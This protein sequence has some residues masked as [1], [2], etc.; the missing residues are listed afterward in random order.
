MRPSPSGT[1]TSAC[2]ATA[3]RT[4][5][6]PGANPHHRAAAR[7]STTDATPTTTDHARIAD[8]D[9]ATSWA[10]ATGT[11]IRAATSRIP[12]TRIDATMVT[13]TRTASSAFRTP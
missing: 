12:T 8:C 7:P 10:L 6:P 2:T 5:D 4:I 1:A 11:T 3:T 9:R 13:A